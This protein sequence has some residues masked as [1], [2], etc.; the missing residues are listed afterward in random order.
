MAA[1][2][3][4]AVARRHPSEGADTM[5]IRLASVL[6]AVALAIA[7]PA[8]AL[9]APSATFFTGTWTSTDYDGSTQMLIVSTGGRPSVVYQDFFASGCQNYGDRPNTHWTA[10]GLGEVDGTDLWVGFHKS[11]CGPFLQGGY[12]DHYAYDSGTDT[13]LDDF[14]ITWY[15]L[16]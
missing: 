7:I 11:G 2:S 5:K 3:V 16:T 12:G 6:A 9:A 8:T 14:G 13:L 1:T 4:A 10:A 15:R